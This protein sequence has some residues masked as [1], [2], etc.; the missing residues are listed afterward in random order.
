M[1]THWQGWCEGCGQW[2]DEIDFCKGQTVF[3][4]HFILTLPKNSQPG[5]WE[6]I[7]CGPIVKW[8]LV[9]QDG[10]PV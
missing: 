8:R 4:D 6:F 1:T 7:S 5:E 2:V 9:D 10:R 3:D